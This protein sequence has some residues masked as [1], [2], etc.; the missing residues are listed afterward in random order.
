MRNER[1]AKSQKLILNN[2]NP[3]IRITIFNGYHLSNVKK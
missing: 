3:T 2:A 1:K